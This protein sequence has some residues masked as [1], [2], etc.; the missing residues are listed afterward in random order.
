MRAYQQQT[1]GRSTSLDRL[2]GTEGNEALTSAAAAVLTLLLAAEGLT[3]LDLGPLR[4][5]HMFIGLVL[6]PPVLVKLGSTGY[7]FARYYAGTRPYRE[8]G[9][10][11]MPLRL[12]A[13]VLVAATLGVFASGVAL[14]IVGHRTGWLLQVHQA[15]FVVWAAASV[16]TSWPICRGWPAPWARTGPPPGVG[17]F[18]GRACASHCL[19]H[20]SP[21]VSW[22][23]WRSS[24]RSRD[25]M[26]TRPFDPKPSRDESAAKVARAMTTGAAADPAARDRWLRGTRAIAWITGLVAAGLTAAFS[27]AA[28]HAFKGHDGRAHATRVSATAGRPHSHLTVPPPQHVPAISGAPTPLQAPSQPPVAA[29]PEQA[30]PPEVSGG[31]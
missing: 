10:P 7:R 31:S 20:R 3:L 1:R 27:I 2:G 14:L 23:R 19:S 8:K 5:P 26:A 6:I 18:R 9:P 4:V 13:P 24:P 25:G 15:S 28:A 29:A 11:L 16:S 21:R 22:W 12:L 17:K 30:P